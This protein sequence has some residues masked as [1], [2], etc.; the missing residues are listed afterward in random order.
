MTSYDYVIAGGGTAGC[1]LAARL[2]EDPAV[3]VCLIEAGP[4]DVEDD[5]DVDEGAPGVVPGF[6]VVWGVGMALNLAWPRSE[7]YGEP[8]Y[9]TWGAFVYIGIIFGVG[10]VWYLTVGRRHIGVLE[11]HSTAT[12]LPTADEIGGGL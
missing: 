3:T 12:R 4:S 9:N 6:A 1:V 2:S 5:A 10:F 11:S 8:W 7:I